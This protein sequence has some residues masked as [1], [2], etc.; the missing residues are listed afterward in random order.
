MNKRIAGL[1]Q[2]VQDARDEISSL[3][4][5]IRVGK[6]T[7]G[8]KFDNFV[9]C[10]IGANPSDW[11]PFYSLD[12]Q[13]KSSSGEEILIV[14]SKKELAEPMIHYAEEGFCGDLEESNCESFMPPMQF[15]NTECNLAYGVL[16]GKGLDFDLGEAEIIFPNGRKHIRVSA[17]S[18]FDYSFTFNPLEVVQGRIR[19]EVEDLTHL[20][21]SCGFEG[22]KFMG[23]IQTSQILVGPEV[24]EYFGKII[25]GEKAYSEIKKKL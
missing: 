20:Y 5:D 24:G 13:M 6:K 17:S 15:Y 21:K 2:A 23:N 18:V 9:F 8:N 3:S 7:L 25:N 10:S 1:Y 14:C 12:E 11:M 4:V 19:K 16:T 22:L